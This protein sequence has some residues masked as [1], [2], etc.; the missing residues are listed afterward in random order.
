MKSKIPDQIKLSFFNADPFFKEDWAPLTNIA[1]NWYETPGYCFLYDHEPSAW[2]AI[3]WEDCKQTKPLFTFFGRT[4]RFFKIGNHLHLNGPTT[5]PLIYLRQLMKGKKALLLSIPYLEGTSS[6][7]KLPW[8]HGFSKGFIGD[9]II[10]LPDSYS[11]YL[12]NLNKAT[13][14]H[15][16]NYYRHLTN[17]LVTELFILEKGE[18]EQGIVEELYNLHRLRMEK[19]NK[20]FAITNEKMTRRIRLAQQCG[21]FCGRY[22]NGKLIAGTLNYY[23]GSTVYLSLVAHNP[24]YDRYHAGLVCLTDT[25]KYLISKGIKIYNLHVRYSPFKTRLGGIEN[26]HYQITLFANV[27][28]T[29]LWY[30]R[31]LLFK[32]INTLKVELK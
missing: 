7:S 18:I 13:R 3:I 4:R 15:L 25:I 5:A 12:K 6:D 29:I 24:Q 20:P 19:V 17:D 11:N 8:W 27:F 22:H 28:V 16:G 21:L 26:K 31:L 30:Y 23:H 32:I 2:A 9:W 10:E 1:K 14:K